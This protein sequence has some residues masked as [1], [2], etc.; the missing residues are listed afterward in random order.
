MS[1]KKKRNTHIENLLKQKSHP[2]LYNLC[3]TNFLFR[4]LIYL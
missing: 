3:E 1:L 2:D 4:F